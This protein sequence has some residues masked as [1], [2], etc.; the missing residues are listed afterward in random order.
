[1]IATIIAAV[2]ATGGLAGFI[3]AIP[4]GWWIAIGTFIGGLILKGYDKW[5]NRDDTK[6][7]Q[8]KDY[9]EQIKELQDRL[10]K[11]E[12]EVTTWRTRYYDEQAKVATLTSELIQA[13]ASAPKP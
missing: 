6:R 7:S 9:R 5:L 10:D 12:D 3:E 1:M 8:A 2:A 4:E 11:V 13:R